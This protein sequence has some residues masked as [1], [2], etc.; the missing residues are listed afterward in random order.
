[1]NIKR[2]KFNFLSS[3]VLLAVFAFLVLGSVF[4]NPIF[5]EDNNEQPVISLPPIQDNGTTAGAE[6]IIEKVEDASIEGSIILKRGCTVTDTDET[7][8]IFP[9]TDSPSEYLGICALEE[10]RELEIIQ[11]FAL[12]NDPN[13]GLYVKNINGIE[14]SNTEFWSLWHNGSFAECGIGCLALVAGDTLSFVLTDWMT[15]AENATI[16]LSISELG[17]LP[18]EEKNQKEEKIDEEPA[19]PNRGSSAGSSGTSATPAIFNLVSALAYLK[20]AQSSDGSF[21]GSDL[22]TDWAAIA[23]GAGDVTGNSRDSLTAHLASRDTII[24]SLL[25]D[26]E[27]RAMALLALGENPYSFNGVNYIGAIVGAFGGAQFGDTD[28]VNDDIFALIPLANAGYTEDDEAIVK[29]VAFLI[30]EQNE[31]G[32]WVGSVDVTAAAIQALKLFD[33]L[34]DVDETISKAEDYLKNA[35]GTDG[36]W[37]NISSTSWAIQA[38]SALNASWRKNGKNGL[39]YLA[40]QQ[41]NANNNSAVLGVNETPEN[42]IWATSYAIAAASGK[43]WNEIMQ[44][45]SKPA[46]EDNQNSSGNS[47]NSDVVKTPDM[48]TSPAPVEPVICPIGDLFSRV[49]GQACTEF[50][51]TVA[52]TVLATSSA[53]TTLAGIAENN[54]KTAKPAETALDAPTEKITKAISPETL[55]G[56]AAVAVQDSAIPQSFPI[57]LGTAS[58]LV[59]LCAAFKFFIA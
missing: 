6:E 57:I 55:T 5:A 56:S 25:T 21:G 29:S 59:L 45:V 24:S 49:T 22:Y 32:S 4:V 13:L 44:S 52:R 54:Q 19:P 31:D 14:P 15:N 33:D 28:L 12:A 2:S 1:M 11:S 3:F 41:I 35:Q 30:S 58:G 26:N 36:G 51:P 53:R 23:F 47:S 38:E 46:K 10:A 42:I 16:T 27:R 20:S 39:D 48:Q 9:N 8:H 40:A 50:T 37:G 18:D 43:T 7:A 17:V 34:G